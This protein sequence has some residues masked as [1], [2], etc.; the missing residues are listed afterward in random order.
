MEKIKSLYQSAKSHVLNKDSKSHI[1]GD[2][3]IVI[4]MILLGLSAFGLGRL[5]ALEKGSDS[6]VGFQN[7]YSTST[8]NVSNLATVKLADTL[9]KTIEQDAPTRVFASKTGKRYYY[10]WCSSQ[11]KE[12]NKV[13]F[14][15]E[16]AAEASGLTL[17]TNCSKSH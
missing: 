15:T 2:V 7:I 5:S 10:S 1:K 3:F 14:D 8:G 17:A 13:W 12:E 6:K 9:P 11:V 4:I 16:G